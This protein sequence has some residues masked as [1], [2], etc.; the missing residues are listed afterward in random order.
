MKKGVLES[1]G[2]RDEHRADGSSG[3]GALVCD[4]LG[5]AELA[6][7]D[8]LV[9]QHERGVVYQTSHWQRVL[10]T[11]FP[12][13]QGK[14]LALRRPGTGEMVGGLPVYEVRSWILGQRRVSIPYA[15]ICDPLVSSRAEIEQLLAG[16]KGGGGRGLEGGVELRTWRTPAEFYPDTP[17]VDRALHHVVDLAPGPDDI[18]RRL[19][20]TAVRRMVTKGAKAGIQVVEG[21]SVAEWQEFYRL[22]TASRR[23]LGLPALPAKFF[24]AIRLRL[25]EANRVLYLAMRE[26]RP[27][28]GALSLKSRQVFILEYSGEENLGNGTGAGQM[29]YWESMR[30]AC[31]DGCRWF[32]FGRTSMD[33]TGLAAY[34]RH[35][36][37]TEEELVSFG[38]GLPQTSRKSMAGSSKTRQLIG[39]LSRH[40]PAALYHL[41]SDFCYR[42]W[43]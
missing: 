23:C 2:S 16:L 33:N 31:A 5:E 9:E 13:I 20:R 18:Y 41:F 12:H 43:G 24:D 28:A 14:I 40:A 35:W 3:A 39:A 25:P 30:R 8:R 36:A 27:V 19:S 10:E 38:P 37:T 11:A 26:G 29:V 42:H 34:K 1:A 15:S 17:V 7:W 21:R 22:L 32:S 6:L 4:W